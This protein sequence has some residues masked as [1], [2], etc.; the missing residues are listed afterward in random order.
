MPRIRDLAPE[1]RN[2]LIQINKDKKRWFTAEN[3]ASLNRS[4]K[5][6]FKTSFHDYSHSAPISLSRQNPISLS[7][8]GEA[9]A[10]YLEDG[11]LQGLPLPK[12]VQTGVVGD[13]MAAH[14]TDPIAQQAYQS[15]LGL[16]KY[17]VEKKNG[18]A[19]GSYPMSKVM[20]NKFSYSYMSKTANFST[21]G[22]DIDKGRPIAPNLVLPTHG[23]RQELQPLDIIDLSNIDAPLTPPKYKTVPTQHFDVTGNKYWQR[24]LKGI[25]PEITAHKQSAKNILSQIAEHSE[26]D[27]ISDELSIRPIPEHMVNPLLDSIAE[28][29]ELYSER[30]R[31]K[32]RITEL[33]RKY[34]RTPFN[35][36]M[37]GGLFSYMSDTANFA[38]RRGII[39][40]QEWL[41]A[42]KDSAINWLKRSKLQANVRRD[43]D[44]TN[45]GLQHHS[46]HDMVEPLQQPKMSDYYEFISTRP[47][48]QNLKGQSRRQS[49]EGFRE[50]IH[51]PYN[52][53]N[54]ILEDTVTGLEGRKIIK[55]DYQ[56]SKAARPFDEGYWKGRKA[57]KGFST[58]QMAADNILKLGDR[59]KQ[60]SDATDLDLIDRAVRGNT[61]NSQ[62]SYLLQKYGKDVLAD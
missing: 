24:R 62:N 30:G 37:R 44:T 19:P 54:L 36:K 2:K 45:I 12:S 25:A 41:P 28:G 26:P 29:N 39:S 35:I 57:R 18:L 40:T 10:R 48:L 11:I 13:T 9:A 47:R 8:E 31:F 17:S 55:D 33:A 23:T 61:S 6:L 50:S 59:R 22:E 20:L 38:R 3:E 46:L 14:N 7:N 60:I 43:L 21:L 1:V 49:I 58:Q 34:S 56:Q 52:K 53:N 27:V 42:L 51:S 5:P 15:L 32:D 4:G 16:G